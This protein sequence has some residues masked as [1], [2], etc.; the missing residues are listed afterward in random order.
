[1]K[2]KLGLT[3]ALTLLAATGAYSSIPRTDASGTAVICPELP[4][5]CCQFKR[6]G[7]CLFCTL[8]CP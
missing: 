1:M 8:E 2:K 7:V 3:L 4:A 5:D 6:V